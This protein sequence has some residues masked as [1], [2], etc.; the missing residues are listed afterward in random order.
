[1]N[2]NFDL[3]WKLLLSVNGIE[4]LLK[5]MFTVYLFIIVIVVNTV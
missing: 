1:M 2:P 4:L 5:N 3:V